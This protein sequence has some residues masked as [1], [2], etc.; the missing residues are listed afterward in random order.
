MAEEKIEVTVTGESKSVEKTGNEAHKIW[1]F[2]IGAQVREEELDDRHYIVV[3]MTMILEGV[4]TGSQGPVYYSIEELA[5]TPKMWNMKPVL[6]E[7]PFRGDTA[8]DLEVYKKQAVGMIMN[9]HFEDGKLKAEAWIDKDLASKK[10]PDLLEHIRYRLPMEVST[11]LFSEL[12]LE[13]GTWQGEEYKGRIV[14]IRADHL[15]ILPHKQGACSLAD[16]AG[17][18]INQSFDAPEGGGEGKKEMLNIISTIVNQDYPSGTYVVDELG[19]DTEVSQSEEKEPRL[20]NQ[21]TTEG[22]DIPIYPGAQPQVIRLPDGGI[23]T[24]TPPP[25][26]SLGGVIQPMER[27][28][29]GTG[30]EEEEEV[31][32]LPKERM[33][34]NTTVLTPVEALAE[35]QEDAETG[36]RDQYRELREGFRRLKNILRSINRR[37][38]MKNG[39]TCPKKKRPFG[40]SKKAGR[41]VT[42]N[43]GDDVFPSFGLDESAF[44]YPKREE[45]VS[46]KYFDDY[47]SKDRLA[48]FNK[49][50]ERERYVQDVLKS[51]LL[52][53]FHVSNV[54]KIK[55]IMT[56]VRENGGHSV[57][58]KESGVPVFS[59]DDMS[60]LGHV[61]DQYDQVSADLPR[62]ERVEADFRA[63]TRAVGGN[64]AKYNR[65]ISQFTGLHKSRYGSTGLQ[66]K[67]KYFNERFSK[68][69][70]GGNRSSSNP[71]VEELIRDRLRVTPDDKGRRSSPAKSALGNAALALKFYTDKGLYADHLVKNVLD[72]CFNERQRNKVANLYRGVKEVIGQFGYGDD[73]LKKAKAE[74]KTYLYGR[75]K[76]K[77]QG[78]ARKEMEASGFVDVN[79]LDAIQKE[80]GAIH[81]I[82]SNADERAILKEIMEQLVSMALSSHSYRGKRSDALRAY[83]EQLAKSAT[84]DIDHDYFNNF[85]KEL[86][87]KERQKKI[88]AQ[89]RNDANIRRLLYRYRRSEQIGAGAES[90]IGALLAQ[91]VLGAIGVFKDSKYEKNA[92]MSESAKEILL[93]DPVL[94][95][96]ILDPYI[97]S[98]QREIEAGND[99]EA[100]TRDLA[101][102]DK[103]FHADDY[104]TKDEFLANDPEY[105]KLLAQRYALVT[106]YDPE[107]GYTPEQMELVGLTGEGLGK[108]GN[109]VNYHNQYFQR[110]SNKA[111]KA[112]LAKLEEE[113]G[114]KN[115]YRGIVPTA[116]EVALIA[117]AQLADLVRKGGFVDRYGNRYGQLDD[118][119]YRYDP[120]VLASFEK[121]M[122]EGGTKTP[123]DY[124]LD[125]NTILQGFRSRHIPEKASLVLSYSP[126]APTLEQINTPDDSQSMWKS[127]SDEDIDGLRDKIQRLTNA[128]KAF[129]RRYKKRRG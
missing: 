81:D 2:D 21:E 4:H 46:G 99:I 65:L 111:V 64:D 5:K 1:N 121:K 122:G 48:K 51:I 26:Q 86:T 35:E 89:S 30:E 58:S 63:H 15:A 125:L 56:K 109:R 14:N 68:V 119:G 42:R 13:P 91:E 107:K 102:I 124:M 112:R 9:T 70:S 127:G 39:R 31:P 67:Q 83:K 88:V 72:S 40:S 118:Y 80:P 82:G 17:L 110:A 105:Q 27:F 94:L 50:I 79:K 49:D 24:Y 126:S 3:P 22:T 101:K 41:V 45:A 95:H 36:D 33:M 12:I 37:Y 103:Y 11:G 114:K 34:D 7:H 62:L 116:E 93:E 74:V 90:G 117:D 98:Y 54:A 47:V 92:D 18:L 53:A 25:S 43:E 20:T 44:V 29:D 96:K 106:G 57:L 128:V 78:E 75:S 38:A 69:L 10:Y 100:N 52:D 6:I 76:S 23:I 97:Q 60:F 55:D 8:T 59:D 85:V 123:E 61:L 129:N 32:T 84:L 108:G 19:A 73:D 16:G 115:Y 87:S 113:L 104:V 28:D 66:P 71:F 77:L 120:S